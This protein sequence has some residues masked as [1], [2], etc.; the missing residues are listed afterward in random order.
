MYAMCRVRKACDRPC[1]QCRAWGL[2]TSW[3]LKWVLHRIS[4]NCVYQNEHDLLNCFIVIVKLKICYMDYSE[5]VQLF[6][7]LKKI[8]FY[9]IKYFEKLD[10][11]EWVLLK[12][13][14]FEKD[15]LWWNNWELDCF[16]KLDCYCELDC[17]LKLDRYCELDYFSKLYC[18][19]ELYCYCELDSF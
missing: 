5:S 10:W 1:I 13:L 12:R 11:T 6:I 15:L 4:W 2:F 17:F 16:W 3:S 14:C 19:W 7:L 18:Y 8:R 9:Y